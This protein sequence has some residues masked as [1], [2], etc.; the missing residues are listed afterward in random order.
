M[1]ERAWRVRPPLLSFCQV[2]SKLQLIEPGDIA[3][4]EMFWQGTKLC[5]DLTLEQCGVGTSLQSS[6]LFPRPWAQTVC[7]QSCS[8]S[9]LTTPSL[10]VSARSVVHLRRC[11][12]TEVDVVEDGEF[13]GL[14]A[15]LRAS[16]ASA[17]RAPEKG[18]AGTLLTG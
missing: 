18:F 2:L 16:S 6:S 9:L 4:F 13:E 5:P 14:A 7:S 8:W 17:P 10:Q 11:A 15:A 3:R 12:S 1:R